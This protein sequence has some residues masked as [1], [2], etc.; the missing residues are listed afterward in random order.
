MSKVALARLAERLRDGGFTLL[1]VQ[2]LTPHLA[3]F[4]AIEIPGREYEA[5][6]TLALARDARF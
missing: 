3:Q 2:Y 1:E 6:L 4:G 5:R